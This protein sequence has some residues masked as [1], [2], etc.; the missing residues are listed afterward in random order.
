MDH[1]TSSVQQAWSASGDYVEVCLQ[2]GWNAHGEYVTRP[3]VEEPDTK[4][5]WVGVRGLD[6]NV[7]S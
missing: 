5:R 4:L 6:P 2:Q 7:G 3:E 1:P